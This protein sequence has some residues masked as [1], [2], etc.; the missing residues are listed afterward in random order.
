MDHHEPLHARMDEEF[1]KYLTEIKPY[2]MN[3][4]NKTYRNYA[5]VW[6]RKLCLPVS[7]IAS[8]KNRN[9]YI[10]LLFQMLKKNILE[11][12]F[13]EMPDEGK[14]PSLTAAQLAKFD[15]EL[16]RPSLNDFIWAQGKTPDWVT[17][18]L[19]LSSDSCSSFLSSTMDRTK[20]KSANKNDSDY[21][22]PSLCDFEDRHE[23][24]SDEFNKH[25][26]AFSDCSID[27]NRGNLKPVISSS[28]ESISVG[29]YVPPQSAEY[30]SNSSSVSNADKPITTR[31]DVQG[32]A[33]IH[34]N[35]P[36]DSASSTT[37]ASTKS[38]IDDSQRLIQSNE[39]YEKIKMI[40]EK[41]H[42]EKLQDQKKHDEAVTKILDR[43]NEEIEELKKNAN[44]KRNELEKTLFEL[45]NEVKSLK[46]EIEKTKE[47]KDK[48]IEECKKEMENMYQMKKNEC[49][50]KLQTLLTDMEQEKVE[51]RRQHSQNIKNMLDETNTRLEKMEEAYKKQ[52]DGNINMIK[53]LEGR[54]QELVLEAD[55]I[56]KKRN[57]L[58][59]ENKELQTTIV[60]Q[61]E[62][63]HSLKQSESNLL[64]RL[65]NLQKQ[66]NKKILDMEEDFRTTFTNMEQKHKQLNSKLSE[67]NI[68][69]EKYI[70][71]LKQKLQ[72]A[73]SERHRQIKEL[74]N[75]Y[76]ADKHQL[77]ELH[78]KQV[79]SLE[80]ELSQTQIEYLKSF[81]KME[82]VAREKES[83]IVELR[84][85]FTEHS[86]QTEK[87]VEQ[88]KK[89]TELDRNKL[90]ME[91]SSQIKDKENE[92]EQLKELLK[93]QSEEFT[94]SIEE[95]KLK[96]MAEISELKHNSE[97]ENSRLIKE[98]NLEKENQLKQFNKQKEE[99]QLIWK[100]KVDETEMLLTDQ[101]NLLSKR[102]SDLEQELKTSQEK[103]QQ[104]KKN[105]KQELSEKEAQH[106]AEKNK[107]VR[108][109]ENEISKM[110]SQMEQ[111]RNNI[112]KHHNEEMNKII[113]KTT[114]ELKN[115]EK[116]FTTRTQITNN[117]I[118]DLQSTIYKLKDDIKRQKENSE[119]INSNL[120][121][122][123]EEK[124]KMIRRQNT[125]ALMALQHK[126]D[127][128]YSKS[129]NHERQL[130][131]EISH[132]EE[133]LAEIQ[134]HYENKIKGLMPS[135]IHRE[136]EETIRSLKIQVSALQKRVS[137]LQS[138]RRETIKGF[139][140]GYS[141]PEPT[142][143]PIASP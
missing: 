103:C 33:N 141:Y 121:A 116:E 78:D 59:T 18:E 135:S 93:K 140:P 128:D 94:K 24:W 142:Y 82:A 73:E 65:E 92:L 115:L 136:L 119:K 114:S 6:I 109:Q 133:K 52:N 127:E 126:Y 84:K 54:V 3:L 74:E 69:Q 68:E 125:A 70:Q 15:P 75:T 110:H 4:N 55:S 67:S 25:M 61:K 97:E 13:I 7:G 124:I 51:L 41:F 66:H 123:H 36:L 1:E 22:S 89:E 39:C 34:W 99:L 131:Q 46:L 42:E 134:I 60:N 88:L 48:Q 98:H 8:R 49:D 47:S 112:Q 105:S 137:L 86:K 56:S 63:I 91:L 108:Q 79:Q 27:K 83:E 85:K 12:P 143:K 118:S 5:A 117:T 130:E 57:V 96:Y 50:K 40:E 100:N 53:D 19:L 87:Y 38:L 81:Q 101:R 26:M 2:V 132:Y 76:K 35:V 37:V 64:E 31:I 106:E 71:Q 44:E 90:R 104:N 10:K 129:R 20:S 139:Y 9:S 11:E 111:H 23:P 14:L 77:E 80:N 122:K 62:E 95:T 16:F 30:S 32:G 43:K 138:D 21:N 102:I 45:E 107:L 120:Q 72:D 58:E 17:D 29:S 28:A 113:E